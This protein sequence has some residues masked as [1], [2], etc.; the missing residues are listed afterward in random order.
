MEV[1]DYKALTLSA[2]EALQQALDKGVRGK[3]LQVHRTALAEAVKDWEAHA[4]QMK[5]V[6]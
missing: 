4:W 6:A 5:E 2:A 1:R 3:L